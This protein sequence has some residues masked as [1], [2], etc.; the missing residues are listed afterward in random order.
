[1]CWDRAWPQ[2]DHRRNSIPVHHPL[3]TQ[4]KSQNDYYL[5]SFAQFIQDMPAAARGA[6]LKSNTP[7]IKALSFLSKRN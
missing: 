5:L 4:P 1:M 6:P 3:T 7:V 2:Q